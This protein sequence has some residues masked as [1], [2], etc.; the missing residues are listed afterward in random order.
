MG[1]HNKISGVIDYMVSQIRQWMKPPVFEGDE[2]KTIHASIINTFIINIGAIL[3]IF[4]FVL[5][6]FFAVH[7]IGSAILLAIVFLSLVTGRYLLFRG[8]VRISSIV[9][10]SVIWSCFIFMALVSGGSHSPAMFYLASVT[11]IAGFVLDIR[12]ANIFAV[13]TILISSMDVIL[14]IQGN[15]LPVIFPFTPFTGW[16]AFVLGL[17]FMISARNIFVFNHNKALILARQEVAARRQAEMALRE[18]EERYR[19]LF[20][21]ASDGI[22]YLSTDGK[23]LMVNESFA[24]MH[25]YS[26]EEMKDMPLQDLDT[27]EGTLLSKERMPRVLSGEIIEFE[28]E[29]YHRD[30]HV[31]PLSVSTGLI[32]VGG[33]QIIQAFH[34]DITERKRAEEIL[35][36]SEEKY[37]NLFRDAAIGIFHSTFDGRF[38]DLNP[39]MAKLLGYDTP[40]EVIMDITNIAEQVYSVA[41]ERDVIATDA[42]KSG[43]LITT[44]NHFRHRD[45]TLWYGRMHMRIVYDHQG[46]P[47]HYEGFVED[48]TGH[49]QAEKFLKDII[50]KNPMSIQVLDKDGLTLEVNP[51]YKLLFG[52]VP[53]SDYSIFNDSQLTQQGLGEIFDRL[54]NGEIVY[55]PDVYFN[56]RNSISELPDVSVCVQTIGFPLNDSKDKPEK[57]VLMHE[58]ITKR[59]QAEDEVINAKVRAEENETKYKTLFEANIDGISIFR[60]EE[61]GFPRTI[62]DMNENAHELLGYTKDEMIAMSPG[63]LESGATKENIEKRIE[64]LK[65]KG[66]SSFE[67]T[68]RHKKGYDLNV[69]IKVIVIFYENQPALMN[70]VRDITGRKRTEEHIIKSL[71]EKET[72]IREVYHRTKNTMQVIRGM[73]V[74]QAADFPENSEM[75]HLVKITEDRIQAMSLVHQMLYQSQDLSQISIKEYIWDLSQLIFES[76]SISND[77][78]VLDISIDDHYFLL[79]TAIP[80]GLILNE[81]ITN[82]LKFAFPDNRKGIIRIV[83]NRNE[84]GNVLRYS[85]NGAGAPDG[86]DFRNTKTLGL[87]LIHSIGEKQMRGRVIMENQNGVCVSFTF[88]DSHYNA[89]V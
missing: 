8:Q 84:S 17:V 78:I 34:R 14:E 72:L 27:P 4:S 44:E 40:E 37:Y 82:S 63:D 39:A 62:L 64:D 71:R 12:A 54:R 59:R 57:F 20:E 38:I 18:S 47:G 60:L 81:L 89:R 11:L 68:L 1:S 52:S 32:S 7:K 30:G 31:F 41:P 77:K 65:T 42:K 49:R 80:L 43:G 26:V 79:D 73:I 6:P 15:T 53:P 55:F 36:A 28:V 13:L 2:D 48:I 86:F 22:F 21:Q 9:M 45:G 33:K 23:V 83:L 29:H 67:T 85:D 19:T 56:A 88:P 3:L 69:E 76:Y 35:R 10:V 5:I 61:N 75:Q 25:G 58:N 66:L 50:I 87:K 46:R 16:L 74:L 51:S 24:R 70:I